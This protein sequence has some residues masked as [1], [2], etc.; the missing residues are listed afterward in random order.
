MKR[1]FLLALIAI[2]IVCIIWY[3]TQQK[4]QRY[5]SDTE[6]MYSVFHGIQ[7]ERS[8][9][10]LTVVHPT[11]PGYDRECYQGYIWL[12]T[13]AVRQLREDYRWLPMKASF[14]LA[15]FTVPREIQDVLPPANHT[16]WLTLDGGPTKM[17]PYC[18]G[19][20]AFNEKYGVIG[21]D[22]QKEQHNADIPASA[23]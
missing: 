15:N 12:N 10:R 13:M 21:F 18:T 4:E 22:I 5:F 20:I 14:A 1:V 3:L 2:A 19:T 16:G 23:D 11:G 6:R 8:Y 7:V 17:V 9:Y